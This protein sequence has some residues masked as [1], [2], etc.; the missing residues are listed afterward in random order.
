MPQELMRLIRTV[1]DAAQQS[2]VSPKRNIIIQRWLSL[3]RGDIIIPGDEVTIAG[4]GTVVYPLKLDYGKLDW[5]LLRLANNYS[6]IAGKYAS[7]TALAAAFA[8]YNT[9]AAEI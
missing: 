4:P 7:Y 8:S 2:R 1:L 9:I 6:Q 3:G 5:A